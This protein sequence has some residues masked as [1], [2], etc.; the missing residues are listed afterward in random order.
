MTLPS[1]FFIDSCELRMRRKVYVGA[2]SKRIFWK[3]AMD[4]FLNIDAVPGIFFIYFVISLTIHTLFFLGTFSCLVFLSWVCDPAYGQIIIF[5]LGSREGCRA[6][7]EPGTAVQ[8]PSALTFAT[9]QRI[10]FIVLFGSGHSPVSFHK[11]GYTQREERF[12]EK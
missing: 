10:I 7:I 1:V 8:K 9:M 5:L 3:T 4:F 12:S 2:R 11:T 6:G